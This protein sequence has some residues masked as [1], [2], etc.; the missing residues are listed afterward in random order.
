VSKPVVLHWCPNRN[1][2]RS[3]AWNVTVGMVR[4]PGLP[5]PV[6]EHRNHE[7]NLTSSAE[8]PGPGH[9]P[10]PDE[11]SPKGKLGPKFGTSQRDPGRLCPEDLRTPTFRAIYLDRPPPNAY[12]VTHTVGSALR[13]P[14]RFTRATRFSKGLTDAN[15]GPG[16]YE[17][18]KVDRLEEAK[19]RGVSFTHARRIDTSRNEA[20][21]STMPGPG[22]YTPVLPPKRIRSATFGR[23]SRLPPEPPR[24]PEG[25]QAAVKSAQRKL[26]LS[27]AASS[28]SAS[29]TVLMTPG[30]SFPRAPRLRPTTG[31]M[32]ASPG[33]G[34][35]TPSYGAI[36]KV[37]RS[38]V[39][40]T[41]GP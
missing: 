28:R 30:V 18:T 12:D 13:V 32:T 39:L 17:I 4:P 40:Y 24:I 5:R 7:L 19:K 36:D 11:I 6:C 38:A 34:R 27:S 25:E 16:A 33:V 8:V 14:I 26:R 31:E 9:Y 15:P 20:D 23:S 41:G 21:T 35:Y 10:L 1:M 37:P 29:T 3:H 22:A 2:S